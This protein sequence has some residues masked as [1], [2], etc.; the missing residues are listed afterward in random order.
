MKSKYLS[1]LVDGALNPNTLSYF[2]IHF[3]SNYFVGSVFF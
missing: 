2:Y 1:I 3:A